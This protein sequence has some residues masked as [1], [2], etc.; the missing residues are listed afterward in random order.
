MKQDMRV[1]FHVRMCDLKHDMR[2]DMKQDT[3][4]GTRY[5]THLVQSLDGSTHLVQSLL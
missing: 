1:L 5:S 3:L 4:D 2:H